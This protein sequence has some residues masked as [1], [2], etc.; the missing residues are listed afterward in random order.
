MHQEETPQQAIERELKEELGLKIK[1]RVCTTT[2]HQYNQQ[3]V[4]Y[5]LFVHKFKEDPKK[6]IALNEEAYTYRWLTLKEA[7]KLPLFED[8]E[9]CLELVHKWR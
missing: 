8:E 5:H 2:Y 4:A 6:N 3:K 7:K 9:Y 1:P